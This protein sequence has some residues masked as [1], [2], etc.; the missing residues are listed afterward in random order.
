MRDAL[1]CVEWVDPMQASHAEAKVLDSVTYTK[2]VCSTSN[3]GA[4]FS[5]SRRRACLATKVRRGTYK[6]NQ[7]LR[8][9]ILAYD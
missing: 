6:A 3:A 2:L 1:S 5:S 7:D 8:R 4:I 9:S